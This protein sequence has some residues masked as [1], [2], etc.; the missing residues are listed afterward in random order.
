ML[1]GRIIPVGTKQSDRAAN[2][3]V[4]QD[5]FETLARIH[6]FVK[7]DLNH[8]IELLSA[9]NSFNCRGDRRWIAESLEICPGVYDVA[10]RQ[11]ELSR[12]PCRFIE[13][14]LIC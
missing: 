12:L 2:T 13:S 9:I 3:M 5:Q 1:A 4:F 11:E 7:G 6:P 10:V 14:I 8:P